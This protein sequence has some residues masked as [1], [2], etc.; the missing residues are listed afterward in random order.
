MDSTDR[1]TQGQAVKKR[2]NVPYWMKNVK[3]TPDLILRYQ[4][5]TKDLEEALKSDLRVLREISQVKYIH[6][7]EK[8]DEN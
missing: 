7:D 8:I 2:G 6:L 3:S 5:K 1:N 4:V